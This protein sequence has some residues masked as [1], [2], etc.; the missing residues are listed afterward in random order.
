[1]QLLTQIQSQGVQA[2][3]IIIVDIKVTR[4]SAVAL[5]LLLLLLML[6]LL[7]LLL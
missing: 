5:M 7:L 4:F 1:M 3:Q 2:F 6:L